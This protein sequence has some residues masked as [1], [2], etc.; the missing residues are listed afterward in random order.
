MLKLPYA[1]RDFDKLISNDCLYIDRTD[2]IPIMEKLGYELLLLRPRRFGKSLWLSTLMY[3]YDIARA[4]DFQR[5]FGHLAIGQNPTPSHNQ[6]M[7]MQWDFSKVEAHDEIE[8]IRESLYNRINNQIGKFQEIYRNFLDIEI[9]INEH[10]AL[11]SFDSLLTAVSVS[12][13]KLY[14]F[15]DEYDNFANEILMGRQGGN[16]ERY[17]DLVSGE[18]LLKTLFKNLKAAGSGA[19]MD[20][21][22]ITGVT[23]VAM[24]DMTSGPN[25]NKNV[26][27]HPY[28]N[29]LCGFREDEVH[30]PL[31]QIAEQCGLSEE[32][33]DEALTQMRTFYNGSRFITRYPG[34]EFQ[35][36]PKVY[37]PI[38][39]FYF[40]EELQEFCTY[41]E[42]M[43]DANLSPDYN[44]LIY[45]SGY[46]TGKQLISDVLDQEAVVTISELG[47]GWGVQDLLSPVQQRE[48][49]AAL[50]C[51]LGA[52]T[53]VG[54]S[55]MGEVLLAIPNLVMRKLYAE[56]IWEMAF[57]AWPEVVAG[58][59]A[60]NLLFGHG[61]IAPLCQFVEKYLLEVYHN[62]DYKDFNELTLKSLFIAL[63]HHSELYMMDSE[64]A[65]RRRYGDL[66]ML[67]RPDMRHHKVA[68]LLIEFKYI[69]LSKLKS[70]NHTPSGD[71]VLNMGK[72]KLLKR[73]VV[74]K[75]LK[76]AREQLQSYRKTLDEKYGDLL[77]L[78]SYAVVGIGFE[79]LLWEEVT[80]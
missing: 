6:Y 21:L 26:S 7:V 24:N 14:L 20:R 49:L 34:V 56:R 31:Q 72:D 40:L 55:E 30:R 23:P 42:D 17:E 33:I 45:V 9:E 5:L 37:N 25:V 32:K 71:E 65:I 64:P 77:R 48:R 27:W 70:G 67:I 8:K 1:I 74:K 46:G 63:L 59:N 22:F 13:H 43:L 44:K 18:G 19:G 11:S 50:L 28:L 52:L 4:D 78:R 38:L 36:V 80:D 66:I 15:I 76:D 54:K 16:R 79:H 10:D 53:V 58:R 69:P 75:Y 29:D 12:N 39:T 73:G 41:P 61:D 62:R 51:Y 3:Y 35:Q 60:A 68:D 47:S 57:K 2:R